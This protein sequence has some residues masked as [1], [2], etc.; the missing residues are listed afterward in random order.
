VPVPEVYAVAEDCLIMAW[1]DPGRATAD[2]AETLARGL[3]ATHRAGADT[4]GAKYNGYI[5]MAPLLNEPAD[6]WPEFWVARRLLPYLKI[7][8]D[9]V[10]ISGPDAESIE[11]VAARIEDFAGPAEPPARLHGDLWSGNI[12]WAADGPARVMDPAAYAGHRESDLAMLSL[13]GAPHLARMLDA[14]D[15]AYPLADGWRERV[16]LHQIHPLLVHAILFGGSYGSRAGAAARSLL[17]GPG[18]TD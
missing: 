3:A 12:V 13:F 14:Y 1:I 10:A 5:G 6:T 15:E 7:A 16:P 17:D 11:K 4:F 8:R 2:A 9:R 18:A